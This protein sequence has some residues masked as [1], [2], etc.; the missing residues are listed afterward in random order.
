MKNQDLR[1]IE[2]IDLRSET[3]FQALKD[4]LPTLSERE[5]Y[6]IENRYLVENAKTW[7]ELSLHLGVSK[8]RV[9]QIECDA[10]KRLQHPAKRKLLLKRLNLEEELVD[11]NLRKALSEVRSVS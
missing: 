9:R 1:I 6:I 7:E 8:E 5:A 3:T 10:V 2:K 4:I 11:R